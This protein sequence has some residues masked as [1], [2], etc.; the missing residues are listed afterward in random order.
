MAQISEFS[1]VFVA[2]GI[3]LGHVDN[4]ALGLITLV[5]LVTITMST[6]MIL[7]SQKLYVI[8]QPYLHW[9]ERRNPFRESAEGEAPMGGHE[10]IIFLA[11]VVTAADSRSGLPARVGT[12]SAW[13]SIRRWCAMRVVP[14]EQHYSGRTALAVH[15]LSEEK[16]LLEKGADRVLFAH[17]DAA[18][19]AAGIICTDPA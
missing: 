18:D 14:A 1:I 11:S 13:T 15:A 8:F 10:I 5:G 4:S 3:T 17:R 12:C 9:F 19:Y 6:Y 2:M 16:I 7:Y